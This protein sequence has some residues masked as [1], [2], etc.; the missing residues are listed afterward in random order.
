MKGSNGKSMVVLP[1][2]RFGIKLNEKPSTAMHVWLFNIVDNES[3]KDVN[4][5]DFNLRHIET[6]QTMIMRLF[7]GEDWLKQI[8]KKWSLEHET[9]LDQLCHT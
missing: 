4:G 6:I 2:S 5:F 3:V 9:R 1:R 7:V 8:R